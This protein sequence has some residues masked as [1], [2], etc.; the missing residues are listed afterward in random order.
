MLTLRFIFLLIILFFKISYRLYILQIWDAV[1]KP[2]AHKNTPFDE[3][4]NVIY[5]LDWLLCS[6]FSW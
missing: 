4:F 5:S 2:Q 3:F 1:P 6:L